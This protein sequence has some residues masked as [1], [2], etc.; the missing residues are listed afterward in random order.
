MRCAY[1]NL[2]DDATAPIARLRT[3][4]TTRVTAVERTSVELAEKTQAAGRRFAGITVEP[5]HVGL[6][7]LTELIENGKIR[8][9]V[10]HVLAL[11]DAAKAHDLIAKGS[12]RGKIVLTAV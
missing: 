3:P 5:D 9:H 12:V 7:R 6:E 8:V 2:R 1:P 11:R 10:S 4:A